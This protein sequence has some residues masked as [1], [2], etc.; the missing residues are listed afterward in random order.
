MEWLTL[1]NILIAAGILEAALG[2][3]PNNWLP[4]R[5]ILLRLIKSVFTGLDENEIKKKQI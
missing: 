1:T 4:Y 3:I 2:A 5:S